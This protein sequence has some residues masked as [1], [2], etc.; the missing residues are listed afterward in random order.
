M[1]HPCRHRVKP[2]NNLQ[3]ILQAAVILP[4]NMKIFLIDEQTLFR[5]AM[6]WVLKPLSDNLTLTMFSVCEQALELPA[7]TPTP[8]LILKD[9]HRGASSFKTLNSVC[10]RYP[11]CPVVVLSAEVGPAL[12]RKIIAQG[13]AGFIHKDSTPAQL[14]ESLRQI[15]KGEVFAQDALSDAHLARTGTTGRESLQMEMAREWP[16]LTERQI[17]VFRG[18][19]R[20]LPNKEIARE[21]M[22]SDGTVK[23]HLSAVYQAL[24]V[25]GRAEAVTVAARRGIRAD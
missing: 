19:L 5:E 10:Q 6:R 9:W 14:V 16:V 18:A 3:I 11:G 25:S 20:G 23:Q 22:I 17:D 8:D 12:V 21:L 7:D 24:G 13:A 1:K 4:P 2:S 15:L